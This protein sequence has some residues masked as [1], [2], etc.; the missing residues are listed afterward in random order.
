M[1]CG[2]NGINCLPLHGHSFAFR[3]PA[4]CQDVKVLNVR[5]IGVEE[6]NYRPLV[7]G[8]SSQSKGDRRPVYRGDSFIC[9]SALHA[10]VISNSRGG[11]GIATRVGERSDYQSVDRN[12]IAS[13]GFN[14]TFP[15]SFTFVDDEDV[16]SQCG[17]DP[18]W[19]SLALTV[20]FTVLV[21][22]F[23]TTSLSF[24][25]IIFA[26]VYFQVA[27]ASD[28][29]P[30]SD[31]YSGFSI[32][33]GRFLPAAFV[34]V[35]I[36]LYCARRTLHGLTA[37][38]EKTIFWLGGCWFGALSNYTLDEIP[39]QRLTPHDLRQQ[40]GAIPAL[41]IIVLLLLAIALGQAWA[42]RNEGRLPRYLA[43]YGILAASLL[44]FVAIPRLSLRIHHYILALLLL[45]GTS[46]QTRPSLL[47]Q[48]FLVGLF[49]NGIARW[50]F[51]SVLQTSA[52]LLQ[53]GKLESAL[54]EVLEPVINAT[55]IILSWGTLPK[56]YDGVSVLVNDVERFRGFEELNQTRFTWTRHSAQ[57]P[58]YFRFGFIK[59][60][61]LGGVSF[62]DYTKAAT[63]N[64]DGS[65]KHML[66]GPS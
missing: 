8:G 65:W 12:G 43:I 23:T 50:N 57:Y 42:L 16:A 35:F 13:I 33:T 3:C 22:I 31:F 24:Y 37:Q 63:W 62:A 44:F 39:I 15:L 41:I 40:S 45:P 48:G 19:K 54:P 61:P 53:D 60:Q 21:S 28:P 36:Y 47:Y 56:G 49:L 25:C 2:L 66:A 59:E 7:V 10:G 5:T 30:F 58:E 55:S 26:S 46:L 14:S 1:K 4:N 27:L 29:P 51:D 11:C 32:A 64:T 18:R 38:F 52:D 34:G 17:E 9:A 6:V 20:V